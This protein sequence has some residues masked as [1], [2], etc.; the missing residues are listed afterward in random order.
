MEGAEVIGW[1]VESQ[2]L[3]KSRDLLEL[4]LLEIEVAHVQVLLESGL[5]VGLWNDGNAALGDP[6]EDDLSWG[7]LVLLSNLGDHL[8]L[9]QHWGVGGLLPSELDEG[10]W[11]EGGV[12][13]DGDALLLGQ[14]DES[15][16]DEVWVVLDLEG[17]WTDLGVAEE[18]KDQRSLEVGDTDG[19]GH[20]LLD[21]G[22]HGGPGLLDGGVGELNGGL[23]IVVP[24]WWVA[25]GWVD[26]LQGDWEVDEVE[27]EVVKAPVSELALGNWLDLLLVVE[28]VP[29]LG[30]DEELLT[31]DDSFLD[32][33]GN[34]LTGL[35][36]VAVV[37]GSVK[38]TVT[39]FD[40]VV[41]SVGTSLVVDLPEA[42]ADLWHL[43]AGAELDSWNHDCE[44][45]GYNI[46]YRRLKDLE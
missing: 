13:G 29:Q 40:G 4:R 31:L 17:S 11:T 16:L 10:G 5:G 32:G 37:A 28:R 22:L 7:L 3:V 35:L 12:G 19:A 9:E 43:I 14:A 18:V 26:V 23:A 15:W 24:S 46:K 25:D 30:D 45:Y 6:S 33:A 38:Q 20:L 1:V 21:Q 42:E 8:V 41:D 36:L 2:S 39:S 44:I 27:I 34:T